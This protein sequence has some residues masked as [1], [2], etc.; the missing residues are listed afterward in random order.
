MTDTHSHIYLPEF[1]DDLKEVIQRAIDAGIDKILLPNIDSTTMDDMLH[2]VDEYPDICYP[3]TGLHPT[4]VNETFEE[5]LDKVYKSMTT[6]NRFIAIGEIGMDLYWDKTFASEQKYVFDRQIALAIEN[7]LPVVV[8][9]RDAF[10]EMFDIISKY[11]EN[12][13][14]KGVIHSFSGTKEDA[15][16]I[17]SYRNLYMGINGTVTFKKSSLPEILKEIPVERLLPETDSPYLTPVPFRGKRNES[18]YVIYVVRRLAEIYK[19]DEINVG[20]ILNSNAARLFNLEYFTYKST[21][22]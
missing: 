14:F 8:H 5:E 16:E 17:M 4:S 12:D 15:Q 2:C 19:T 9:C 3:M 11:K 10:R 22:Y 7:G 13:S 18:S 21:Q 20:N 6:P 1:K